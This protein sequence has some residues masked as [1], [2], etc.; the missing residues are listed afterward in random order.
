[1]AARYRALIAGA[2][3][4]AGKRLCELLGADPQWQVV[5]LCRNPPATVSSPRVTY[6]SAVAAEAASASPFSTSTSAGAAS[7]DIPAAKL[8][9]VS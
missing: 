9:T 5:G 6:V 2:T 4:A 3:G 7:I 1:M 8:E